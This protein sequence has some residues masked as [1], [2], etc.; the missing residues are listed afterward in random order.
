MTSPRSRNS[1][2]RSRGKNLIDVVRVKT[3][4]PVIYD[5][6]LLI[7]QGFCQRYIGG[8]RQIASDGMGSYVMIWYYQDRQISSVSDTVK[9]NSNGFVRDEHCLDLPPDSVLT[10][11]LFQNPRQGIGIYIN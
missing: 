3:L 1:C 2:I 6:H 4:T 10:E 8:Y 7:D 11:Q 5:N 9:Q